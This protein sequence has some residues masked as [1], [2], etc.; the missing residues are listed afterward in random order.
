MLPYQRISQTTLTL[1]AISRE[2]GL[3]RNLVGESSSNL[4]CLASDGISPLTSSGCHL[5]LAGAVERI[6][7]DA[8]FH[9]NFAVDGNVASAAFISPW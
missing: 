1:D 4:D 3:S 2:T 5:F 9:F 6:H 8:H 7:P